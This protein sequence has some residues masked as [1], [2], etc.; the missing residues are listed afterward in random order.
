MITQILLVSWCI[1][2]NNQIFDFDYSDFDDFRECESFHSNNNYHRINR[3][4]G[5]HGSLPVLRIRSASEA[6]L[7]AF[8][9]RFASATAFF[10]SAFR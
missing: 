6:A 3:Q 8:S 4:P 10:S 2:I 1:Q 5:V 9:A 7:A